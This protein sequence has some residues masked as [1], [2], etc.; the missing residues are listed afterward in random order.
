MFK[1]C[2][3]YDQSLL[4]LLM[5]ADPSEANVKKHFEDG[6]CYCMMQQHTTVGA[7]I[8]VERDSA[9]A[10]IVC[11]SV[12]EEWQGRGI[13]KQLIAHAGEL[14]TQRGYKSLEV[15]TGNSSIDQL[16]FYQKCG[17]R[18]TGV[19]TNFFLDHYVE[20]IYE[21]GIQCMDMVRLSKALV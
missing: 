4:T 3:K 12:S 6:E 16:A 5:Q 14:T 21:N 11:I 15:G 1:K 9:T 19:E 17:F 13:G 8:L 20:P 2:L 10:E 7:Y 18:I